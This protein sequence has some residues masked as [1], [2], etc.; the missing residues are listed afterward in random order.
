MGTSI[1]VTTL[2]VGNTYRV[3]QEGH[4]LDGQRVKLESM[5]FRKDGSVRPFVIDGVASI[6]EVPADSLFEI[7]EVKP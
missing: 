5:K 7:S 4:R 2:K 3:L 6:S 1:R